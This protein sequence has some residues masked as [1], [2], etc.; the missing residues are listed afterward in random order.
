MG[1]NYLETGTY[2]EVFFPNHNVRYI[3][4]N[5]GVDSINNAQMDITPFRNIINEMYAKDTSRKIKSAL[6]AR[7]MQGK[8]MAA[9]APFG[10]KKDESDHNHLVID[11]VTAPVVELIF[12]IAE[13][14]VG[15]HTICNRL[16]KAKVIK[17]SFYKKGN[18]C[19]SR[20]EKKAEQRTGQ[21][22]LLLYQIPQVWERGL[23]ITHH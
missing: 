2:I 19:Q 20:A 3:A 14:G 1:R 23:F 11:E 18:A 8:Y 5:D 13:E 7:K 21:D 22:F 12:S 4:I 17:P 10:Y 16:R 9:T 6:H 15:L